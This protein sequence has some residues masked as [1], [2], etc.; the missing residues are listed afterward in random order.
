ML[1]PAPEDLQALLD[2]AGTDAAIRRNRVALDDLP[3]NRRLA[4]LARR[5][6][7]LGRQ[8]AD[9]GIECDRVEAVILGHERSVAQLRERLAV[10][11]QRMYSGDITNAKEHQMLQVEI[12]SV[13]GRI[14]EHEVDELE[15]MEELEGHEETIDGIDAGLQEIASQRDQLEATRD[16]S[17]AGLLAEIAE[18]EVTRETQRA[19][20][21]E[22]LVGRYDEVAQR[23]P[24]NAIGSLDGSRCT[25]CG[26][27]L[28]GAAVNALLEGPSLSTCPNCR[29]LIVVD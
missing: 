1:D 7:E 21:P 3:E 26:I 10:E 24:G 6:D 14:D 29:R 11:Q 25:A 20:L 15:A 22:E 18:L 4:E 16:Q 23:S 17:A 9:V 28:S 13:Q 12:A 27:G 5:A 8:R 2:L 19:G